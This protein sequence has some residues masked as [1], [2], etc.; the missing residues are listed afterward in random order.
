MQ[1]LP[2][3]YFHIQ[4][5][6]TFTYI[7]KS[8]LRQKPCLEK[9]DLRWKEDTGIPETDITCAYAHHRLRLTALKIQR[10][11][12]VYTRVSLVAVS[13]TAEQTVDTRSFFP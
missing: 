4:S 9:N 10:K 3:P 13:C 7:P 5:Y 8:K 2:F 11:I 1:I 12:L 6:L